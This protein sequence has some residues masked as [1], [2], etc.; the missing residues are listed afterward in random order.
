MNDIT[1][2]EAKISNTLNTDLDWTRNQIA[3][4][5]VW[6][7]FLLTASLAINYMAGTYASAQ[8][9]NAVRDIVLD[10]VPV[11]DVDGIFTYG[12]IAFFVLVGLLLVQK[13]KRA[14]FVLK[15]LSVFVIIRS[16]FIVLTHIGPA[17]HALQIPTDSIV[18]YFTFTGDLFFSAHTGMPFL[19]ALVFWKDVWLRYFFICASIMFGVIVLLG[20][21][22]YSI[23]VFSAFFITY[24][25]FQICL[26]LFKKE[27]R[28]LNS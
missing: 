21:L 6:G 23:D 2:L 24:G 8:A 4:S 27:Y 11:M 16:F 15:S 17:Q 25:I 19:M 14:P 20:H 22:H 10:N 9:G 3:I 5:V 1:K 18:N 26:R 28:L 12:I 7:L 13:P